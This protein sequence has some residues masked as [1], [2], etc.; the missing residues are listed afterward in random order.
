MSNDPKQEHVEALA[1]AII[2]AQMV[3]DATA[4]DMRDVSRHILTSMN[5]TVLDAMEDALVRAGRLSEDTQT[6]ADGMSG[7]VWSEGKL[8]QS[9][10]KPNTIQRRL[11]TEWTEAK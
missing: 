1:L 6:L 8:V 11:V 7:A 2:D 4:H 5:H 9:F 10:T 3:L